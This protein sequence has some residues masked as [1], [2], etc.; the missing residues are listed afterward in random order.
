[1]RRLF[2]QFYLLLIICFT[3]GVLLVGMIYREVA[4]K[5]G[6]R[7][8]TDLLRTT[9]ALI[10]YDL[11]NVPQPQWP[12]ALSRLDHKLG[13]SLSLAELDSLPIDDDTIRALRDGEIIMQEDN[14]TYLQRLEGTPYVLIA[15]PM[16][17]LVFLQGLRWL[18]FALLTLVG[19][20]LAVPVFIWMRP[21]WRE[22][23]QLE[24][25]ARALADGQFDVRVSLPPKSGLQPLAQGFNHMANSVEQLLESKQSLLNA[26]AH[27]LRTPLARLRYRLALRDIDNANETDSGVERDLGDIGALI[28][29]LLLHAQLTRPDLTLHQSSLPA[30]I[31]LA[32]RLNELPALHQ[33]IPG[34]LRVQH[35]TLTG[36]PTLLA[37]AVD[38]LL[39]NACR[40]AAHH[41]RLEFTVQDGWQCLSVADDGPGI[42][43]IQRT[44]VLEPFVRLD[45]NAE[46]SKGHHGLGLAI[47]TQIMLAHGGRV[48]IGE[49]QWHGAEISLR[50][51]VLQNVTQEN[52]YK[53]TD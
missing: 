14:T 39:N 12:Q 23:Q 1:M 47:V 6:S 15:G 17:Y 3:L 40:Y 8:L 45:A 10:E 19:I 46:R 42:P 34:E 2:I 49:S 53:Q 16:P 21:H 33:S 26:V 31:W 28:D 44:R 36:D 30:Q 20:S 51:P 13:F 37:R 52:N 25:S 5:T 7:L 32:S 41:I 18:D 43:E 4:D 48:D 22:L 35:A 11:R 27:E 24:H 38:N 29:E 9:L 50:W